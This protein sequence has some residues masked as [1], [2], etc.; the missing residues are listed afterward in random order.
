MS[1]L[2]TALEVNRTV[3]LR[4]VIKT[5]NQRIAELEAALHESY[6]TIGELRG[7]VEQLV[8]A[9]QIARDALVHSA[10]ED[11][12]ATGPML[13][14]LMADLVVCPGCTAL[15]RIDAAIAAGK[16]DGDG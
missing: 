9:L 5:R 1:D 11:C 2:R 3:A 13:G 4:G 15:A 6:H 8:T 10:P 14:D 16:G 12:W 7:E